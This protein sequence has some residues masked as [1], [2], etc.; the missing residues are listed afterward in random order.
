VVVSWTG[1]EGGR[2]YGLQTIYTDVTG[3]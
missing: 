3:S 2:S 1:P